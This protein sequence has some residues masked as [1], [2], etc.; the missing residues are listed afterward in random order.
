MV[1]SFLNIYGSINWTSVI[2]IRVRTMPS[3]RPA[4]P[5]QNCR[6]TGLEREALYSVYINIS[7]IITS[8]NTGQKFVIITILPMILGSEIFLQAKN[9]ML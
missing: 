2:A 6:R 9:L 1:L 7:N 3:R 4:P 5:T 8:T